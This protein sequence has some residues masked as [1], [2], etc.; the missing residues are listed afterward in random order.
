MR[1]PS[2][3]LTVCH[4]PTKQEE[5]R[6][7]IARL[8][9]YWHIGGS[10]RWEDND[11]ENWQGPKRQEYYEAADALIPYLHSQG[12]VLKVDRELPTSS[13]N[14]HEY[15]EQND[16]VLKGR[17]QLLDAGYVAVEPLI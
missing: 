10:E 4:E 15:I 14:G 11:E 5:I 8:V 17:N 9:H 3:M 2:D 7:G 1:K 16:F 12:V 13:W 6:E